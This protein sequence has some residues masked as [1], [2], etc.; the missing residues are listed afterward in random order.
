M[1]IVILRTDLGKN[2]CSVVGDS[3]FSRPLRRWRFG[4]AIGFERPAR[5]AKGAG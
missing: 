4:S 1:S 5:I 3:L 2:L